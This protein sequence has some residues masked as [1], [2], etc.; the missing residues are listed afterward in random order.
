[1][2]GVCIIGIDGKVMSLHD[3]PDDAIAIFLN[4]TTFGYLLIFLNLHS[5]RNFMV[6]E[7]IFISYNLMKKRIIKSVFISNGQL[8]K[9]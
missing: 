4:G 7:R 9:I 5:I 6:L 1:M 2:S 8:L 3:K